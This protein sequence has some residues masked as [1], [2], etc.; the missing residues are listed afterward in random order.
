MNLP[1]SLD[2]RTKGVI[3]SVKDQGSLGQ[4]QAVV[5]VGE[6]LLT[7]VSQNYFL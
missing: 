2:W 4:V 7:R 5:A 1:D 3:S 6:F